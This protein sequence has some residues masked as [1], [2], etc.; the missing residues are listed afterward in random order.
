MDAKDARWENWWRELKELAKKTGYPL[1]PEDTEAWL[2]Y[3]HDGYTPND[4]LEEDA[5]YAD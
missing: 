2:G 5:S 3:F 1:D 4:A